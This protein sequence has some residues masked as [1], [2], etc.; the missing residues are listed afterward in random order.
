MIRY[1]L[2]ST[3]LEGLDYRELYR[4]YSSQGRKS[5]AEPQIILVVGII[6]PL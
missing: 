1:V 2:P 4:T 3:Q 6:F 5:E